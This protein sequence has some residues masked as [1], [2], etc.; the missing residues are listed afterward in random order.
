MPELN[1]KAG[2]QES[3]I[4]VSSKERSPYHFGGWKLFFLY[5]TAL[6]NRAFLGN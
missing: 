2:N 4:S 6:L 1:L 3:N 5:T